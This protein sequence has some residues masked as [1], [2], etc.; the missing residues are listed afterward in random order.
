MEL[1]S[2]QEENAERLQFGALFSDAERCQPLLICEVAEVLRQKRAELP[3]E[4]Q[5]SLSPVFTKAETY[6]ERFNQ[7]RSA[8]VAKVV[9]AR[10]ERHPELHPFERTQLANLL[11]ETA[12]EAKSIIPSLKG[13]ID[14]DVLAQLLHDL[15][16]LVE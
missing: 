5:S 13:K 14:D 7:F 9:R 11:P 3:A 15:A 8:E 10:L 2:E 16:A 4:L 12:A 1:G 6:T